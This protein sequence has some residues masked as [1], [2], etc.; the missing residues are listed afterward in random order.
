MEGDEGNHDHE[1][2]R[3]E[4]EPINMLEDNVMSTEPTTL[5]NETRPTFSSIPETRNQDTIDVHRDLESMA[6]DTLEVEEGNESGV[7]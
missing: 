2:H 6:N 1:Q 4:E 3:Q 5:E 7:S